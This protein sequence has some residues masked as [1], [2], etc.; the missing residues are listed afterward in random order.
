[1]ATLINSELYGTGYSEPP[2]GHAFN[3]Y[4]V[5]AAAS[6]TLTDHQYNI[7][8][9]DFTHTVFVEEGSEAGGG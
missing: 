7:V 5:D 4:P 6:A 8:S 9:T 2:A 1:M 3:I